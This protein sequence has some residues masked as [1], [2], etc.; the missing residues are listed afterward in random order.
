MSKTKVR[1]TKLGGAGAEI[2]GTSRDGS[3]IGYH[4]KMNR[5]LESI[6]EVVSSMGSTHDK[7]TKFDRN[8]FADQ[9]KI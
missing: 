1:Y 9:V 7:R 4:Q 8:V 6:D 2:V 5:G 3:P